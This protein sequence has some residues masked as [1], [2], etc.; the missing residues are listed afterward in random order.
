MMM[1]EPDHQAETLRDQ[2]RPV[3]RLLPHDKR[4]V[5]QTACETCAYANWFATAG[6]LNAYC[7]RMYL[8]TW[9]AEIGKIIKL[10]D[11]QLEPPEE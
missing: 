10:C 11:G 1:D 3:L 2:D 5:K 9:P 8:L 7:R 4:P 6:G